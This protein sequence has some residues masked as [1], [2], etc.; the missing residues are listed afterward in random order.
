[1]AADATDLKELIRQH[2]L[3]EGF[4]AVGFTSVD[5]IGPEL[6]ARLDEFMALQRHGEMRWLEDK[7]ERRR[8]LGELEEQYSGPVLPVSAQTGE[9]MDE[10]WKKIA[11]LT[12]ATRP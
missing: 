8:H 4:D 3:A 2:A 6:A 5:R 12:R 11:S 7:A 9:G 1:M 10:L